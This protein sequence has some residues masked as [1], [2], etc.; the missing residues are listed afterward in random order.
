MA[1]P[2]KWRKIENI[3]SFPYFIPSETGVT[4]IPENVLKL[5]E[6][7]AIR[8]KD[9]EGLEQGEC[10]KKMEVSRPTF[11]RIL[12]S[13]RE[14]IADSLVNGKIIHIDGGNFTRNICPVRCLDCGKEWMES[15]ENLESIKNGD[16]LCP[17]C[18][19]AKVICRQNCQ[20]KFGRRNCWRHGW[21]NE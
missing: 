11:Q 12:I 5:E 4:E 16:Y 15:Y 10:A 19:S 3:P 7:E 14:K 17:A 1:R 9:F 2:T 18:G 21:K 8:L 20:G 6:L 13:T